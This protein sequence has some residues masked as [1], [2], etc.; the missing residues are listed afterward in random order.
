MTSE[1]KDTRR[2][3]SAALKMQV[4]GECEA[5]GA[6]VAQV[7]MSH[8]INANVVHRW[9]TLNR[10]GKPLARVTTGEFMPVPLPVVAPA[11]VAPAAL[12]EIR[13]EIRGPVTMTITWPTSAA[14]DL[15]IWTRE[16]LR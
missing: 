2:R 3:Y 15:A 13:V 9:R 11:A 12:A 6:S 14:A 8:G 7:A 1:R 10:K 16:L 4:V 5:P